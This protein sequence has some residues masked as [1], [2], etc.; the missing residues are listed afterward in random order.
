MCLIRC[1][2][3]ECV[4]QVFQLVY[5][6][7]FPFFP[8]PLIL[9]TLPLSLVF[10]SLPLSPPLVYHVPCGRLIV[11]PS[12]FLWWCGGA[13][14][15]FPRPPTPTL[16]SPF[17]FLDDTIRTQ[18]DIH[19]WPIRPGNPA[20]LAVVDGR[21]S[22]FLPPSYRQPL[23]DIH[24]HPW[25]G[26]D[27]FLGKNPPPSVRFELT[28]AG[29]AETSEHCLRQPCGHRTTSLSLVEHHRF[30]LLNIHFQL[31]LPH[32]FPRLL[33]IPFIS[34]SGATP[35]SSISLSLSLS[36]SLSSSFRSRL[37][38]TTYTLCLEELFLGSFLL[39]FS[40]SF[41]NRGDYIF[42]PVYRESLS[43]PH[44]VQ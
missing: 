42:S 2:F 30:R 5:S 28:S 4:T 9:F 8:L 41:I 19:R 27:S 31:F 43:S 7:Y 33:I 14:G 29:T 11:F 20:D 37:T 15:Y 23:K 1:S 38:H 32:I 12:F 40:R 26:G 17:S 18:H 16:S 24:T 36:L 34:L 35:F 3:I 22:L 21:V 44:S 10:L 25:P 13:P 6:F 39:C